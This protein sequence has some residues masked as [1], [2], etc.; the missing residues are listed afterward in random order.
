[1]T[2]VLKGTLNEWEAALP[3]NVSLSILRF[4]REEDPA[5]S[6]DYTQR[7]WY[8]TQVDLEGYEIRRLPELLRQG[9]DGLIFLYYWRLFSRLR[10]LPTMSS[11]GSANGYDLSQLKKASPAPFVSGKLV[12]SSEFI[13]AAVQVFEGEFSEDKDLE[14]VRRELNE[15]ARRELP[16]LYQFLM[17]LPDVPENIKTT[18]RRHRAQAAETA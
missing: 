14:D 6:E 17:E 4:L 3:T 11:T 18:L 10:P 13:R 2:E 8:R 1:L 15:S 9:R 12:L 7:L 16:K 5:H